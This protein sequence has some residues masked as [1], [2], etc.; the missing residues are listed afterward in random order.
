MEPNGPKKG[1]LTRLVRVGGL[2]DGWLWGAGARGR[3][4]SSPLLL[5][6]R[7]TAF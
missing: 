7:I 6:E 3:L 1:P 4:I 5:G 2:V